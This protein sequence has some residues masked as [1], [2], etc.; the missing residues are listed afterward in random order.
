MAFFIEPPI[1]LSLDFTMFP[2]RNDGDGM[3]LLNKFQNVV[4]VITPI[5]NHGLAG[6]VHILEHFIAFD[7]VVAVASGQFKA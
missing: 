2:T 4:H 3:L 7:T 1:T 5:G 6:E